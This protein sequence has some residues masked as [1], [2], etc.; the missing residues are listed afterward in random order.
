M[1]GRRKKA[2]T[3][4]VCR[5]CSM[6]KNVMGGCNC[7]GL[8]QGCGSPKSAQGTCASCNYTDYSAPRDQSYNQDEPANNW[9]ASKGLTMDDNYTDYEGT[10]DGGS[11]N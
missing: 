6:L 4:G 1:W 2:Q 11:S 8:C 5:D 10:E 3:S 9:M 7:N